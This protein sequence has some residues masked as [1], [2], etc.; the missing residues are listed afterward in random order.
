MYIKGGDIMKYISIIE[1]F[2]P[3]FSKSDK[4]IADFF[5]SKKEEISYMSL[6]E[7]TKKIKISEATIVRFVK[8]IGYKGF[9]DF[10]LEVAKQT[11]TLYEQ[12]SGDYIE[13]IHNNIN[14]TINNTKELMNADDIDKAINLI[15]TSKNIYIFGL[16]ASGVA[17]M[18]M[19]NRLLRYGL[20]TTSVTDSQFQIMY[21]ATVTKDDLIIVISLSGE[22]LE[23]V[24]PLTLAKNNKCKIISITNHAMS[25]IAKLANI[26][27]LT[28]GKETPLDGG[29]LVAKISQLYVIDV[30][31]TGYAI[32]NKQESLN[33]KEKIAL[34]IAEKK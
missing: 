2:Y 11:K 6:Q 13:N 21:A 4:K 34:A 1:S 19:E 26:S 27:L 33:F 17:A 12:S 32:K 18:E 10:K 9:I 28:A 8:K 20:F 14:R 29:S 24:Y 3:S 25:T 22:S 15:Q 23:L 16:G 7:I 30:L 31:T 5:L